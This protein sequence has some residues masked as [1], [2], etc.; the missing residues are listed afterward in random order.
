[1]NLTLSGLQVYTDN[2]VLMNA[3]VVIQNGVITSVG[4]VVSGEKIEFPPGYHLIPGFIDLHTH[5]SNGYDVMD[6]KPEALAAIAK[7][8]GAEG[9]TSF[10]AT[11]MTADTQQIEKAL[12]VVSEFMQTPQAG[13]TILGVHLEGPFLA[14][15]KSGAQR[16]DKIILPDIALFK[17]WEKASH[18]AIRLVTLAPE[19]KNCLELIAYLKQ[20][21]IIASLGHTDATYAEAMTAIESGCSYATHLFNAMRGIHHREPGAVTAALLSDA[22][23]VELI[24]DGLHLH[25]AIVKL[26]AQVK[27]TDKIVLVTDAMRAK[28]MADGCYD[29]GGHE[30]HVK[31]GRAQLA[32]G[33]LAGSV[34]KMPSAIR[35]MLDFTGCELKDAVKMAAENPAKVLGIFDKKGSIAVGKDAD[36]V[37][38]NEALEVVL[39]ICK[40]EIIYSSATKVV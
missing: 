6:A 27:G 15:S 1:M 16:G 34:L 31:K 21:K 9:T 39:T 36:C 18:D 32:D 30:V 28:C 8:L 11:T 5:G 20:Q 33:T 2:T 35:N 13:A 26:T 24:V 14:I 22:V 12:I 37:V 19:Q 3:T 40:G 23:T 4:K 38:L 17:R 10:L 29:L 25:P 7:A